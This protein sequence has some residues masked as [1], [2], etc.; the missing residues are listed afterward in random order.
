M[1]LLGGRRITAEHK[2]EKAPND[3]TEGW[4]L[5][6]K[7]WLVDSKDAAAPVPAAGITSPVRD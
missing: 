2:L 1:V 3:L 7:A 6:W 4:N 5:S